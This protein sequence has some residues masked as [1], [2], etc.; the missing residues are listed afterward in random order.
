[1]TLPLSFRALLLASVAHLATGAALA[2][3]WHDK[4]HVAAA[5][6]L[7]RPAYNQVVQMPA[8]IGTRV[9]RI[10]TAPG[11]WTATRL[12]AA[13]GTMQKSIVTKPASVRYEVVPAQY[14]T[15][16]ETVVVGHPKGP[17]AH[18]HHGHGHHHGAVACPCAKRVPQ[19]T[20][21]ARRVMVSP[22]HT[23]AITEPAVYKTV[24][25]PVQLAPARTHLHYTPPRVAYVAHPITLQAASTRI[26][27]HPAVYAPRLVHTAGEPTLHRAA[28]PA[29]VAHPTPKA[30]P[31]A[32]SHAEAKPAPV[33]P[34]K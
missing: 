23:V 30:Q 21:V 4:G 12:P 22:A 1:M 28:A 3:G 24:T 14:K 31:P 11:Y 29:P 8:V 16:H 20:V 32:K 7:V 33:R 13:I 2:G 10:E 15:V 6:Q 17:V 18:G 25:V 27:H 26:V 5:P 19:T 34:S 9:Q